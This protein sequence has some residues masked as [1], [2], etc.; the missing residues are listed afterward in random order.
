MRIMQAIRAFRISGKMRKLRLNATGTLTEENCDLHKKQGSIVCFRCSP[1]I[2]GVKALGRISHV[3]SVQREFLSGKK[4]RI[5]EYCRRF[6]V[7]TS[8]SECRELSLYSEKGM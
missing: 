2:R 1:Q 3:Q 7:G 8:G 4:D 6:D 5:C